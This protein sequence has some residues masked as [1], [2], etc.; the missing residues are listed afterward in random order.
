[1]SLTALREVINLLERAD[2]KVV[3]PPAA[4]RR[5]VRRVERGAA[6]G[7]ASDDIAAARV[8]R[9]AAPSAPPWRAPPLPA[10]AL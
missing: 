5:L 10:A 2:N 7:G 8:G 3:G 6:R 4:Q 9:T 1:M